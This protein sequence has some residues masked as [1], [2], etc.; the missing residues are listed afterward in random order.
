MHHFIIQAMVTALKPALKSKVRAEQ[1][2]EKFWR[3]KTALV[4]DTED[5]HTAANERG[6]ALTSQEAIK[7]LQDL[8]TN[9]NK[10]LGLRWEDVTS[11]IEEYALGRKLTKAE[12][13][14]FVEKNILTI[15]RR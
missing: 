8:H 10:Q 13:K 1:I 7:V 15:Q 9:H 6:V 5:V 2:L 12:L 11:Y 3:D 14:R 4:W